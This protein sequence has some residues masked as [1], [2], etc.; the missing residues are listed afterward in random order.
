ML[1]QRFQQLSCRIAELRSHLL[2]A[3][4]SE[5]GEYAEDADQV[6]VRGLSY[7]VLAHAEIE[8]Y[9]EDRVVEIAKEAIKAWKEARHLS[10][11]L[12]Y[13]VAFS[14]REMR[15]P[16]E[17]LTSPTENKAKEWPTLLDP[18]QRLRDCVT[19]YVQ[20]VQM[21]NHGIR[22]HNLLSM[23]LPVGVD[24]SDLDPVFITDL[25]SFGARRGEAAHTSSNLAQVRQGVNPKDEHARVE[26]LLKGL[27]PI[28]DILNNLLREARFASRAY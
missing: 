2:P 15:R 10:R 20:A 4:F 17:S 19:C 14:G 24:C 18:S 25:D 1:S 21:E 28:D 12:L 3:E 7:R 5:V 22:E 16:P 8:A 11:T 6:T 23:L 27:E 9:F 13:M 26:G